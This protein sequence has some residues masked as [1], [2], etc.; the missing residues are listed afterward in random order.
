[1]TE[2][3]FI[4]G[5]SSK[6]M[7]FFQIERYEGQEFNVCKNPTLVFV[8]V[9]P[10]IACILRVR[11]ASRILPVYSSTALRNSLMI[12]LRPSRPNYWVVVVKDC[13]AYFRILYKPSIIV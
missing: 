2:H 13:T 12:Y 1:M 6:A 10:L 4:T 9:E 7:G 5:I 8:L 3:D 11:L